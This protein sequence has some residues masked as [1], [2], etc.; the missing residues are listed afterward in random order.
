MSLW[1]AL[2]ASVGLAGAAEEPVALWVE[3][4]TVA[5]SSQP[6]VHVVVKNLGEDAYRGSLELKVPESWRISP[7]VREV[8]LEGG[9]SQRVA[10]DVERGLSVE[11]NSYAVEVAAT[12]AGVTVVRR[13]QVVCASAPYYKPTID[14]DPADWDDAIPVTFTSGGKRTVVSTFWNSR[15]FCLLVAV[16]EEK[17]IGYREKNATSGEMDALQLAISPQGT[18]TGTSAGD[19]ARRFEFLFVGSGDSTEGKCFELARPGMPLAEAAKDRPLAALEYEDAEVAVS[20]R[21]GTTYYEI[22]LPTRPM[23][24]RIRPGEG[25]E[26][27]LSLLVHD[28]DGTGVRDWGEAAGLWPWRRNALA[29]SRWQGARWGEEPPFDNK[30]PWGMCSSI[31]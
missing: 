11:A 30:L 12:G 24:D 8:S 1:L 6:L 17:L 20:R 21:G 29:W 5:P 13:Q 25:R 4:F 26:F 16:E 18:V 27:C 10:F 9:E 15:R 31:Y 22:A 23:R 28:P 3:S 14:G 19:E 2:W 7:A